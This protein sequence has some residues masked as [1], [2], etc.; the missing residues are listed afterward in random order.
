VLA[1]LLL[2][3]APRVRD[4]RPDVPEALD[5]LVARMMAKDPA[6]RPS[7]ATE[8]GQEL[9]RFLD[10]GGL[11]GLPRRSVPPTGGASTEKVIYDAASL[12][13]KSA[14]AMKDEE[15]PASLTMS[16]KRLVSVVLAVPRESP[17]S[18]VRDLPEGVRI[19]TEMPETCQRPNSAVNS[20][21]PRSAAAT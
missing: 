4:H 14:V 12:T 9:A 11:T 3:E 1:K 17:W 20:G 5:D 13:S 16:E 21:M 6:R 2:Q 15:A 7:S 8:V 10:A 19:S 18:S